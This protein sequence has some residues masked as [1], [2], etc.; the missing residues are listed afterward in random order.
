M[1]SVFPMVIWSKFRMGQYRHDDH[2]DHAAQFF[3]VEKCVGVGKLKFSLRFLKI[4]RRVI[5]KSMQTKF[6]NCASKRCWKMLVT[7]LRCW[8]RFCPYPQLL[9]R[10][11]GDKVTKKVNFFQA[12]VSD[13][14]SS[15]S[16]H[17]YKDLSPTWAYRLWYGFLLDCTL[18]QKNKAWKALALMKFR[19]NVIK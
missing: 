6:K 14:L 19:N 9:F 3:Y 4:S 7:E 12:P 5:L 10:S 16:Y 2:R 13:R 18:L 1:G 15:T 8:W 11:F 17:C